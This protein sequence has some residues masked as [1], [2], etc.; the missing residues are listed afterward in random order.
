MPQ[1]RE[2]NLRVIQAN[3]E[4]NFSE[5]HYIHYAN[6][7]IAERKMHVAFSRVDSSCF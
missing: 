1:I 2:E 5:F 7:G 3:S 6:Q 4:T